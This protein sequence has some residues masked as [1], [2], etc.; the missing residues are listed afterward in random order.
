MSELPYEL[1]VVSY[2]FPIPWSENCLRATSYLNFSSIN[3]TTVCCSTAAAISC[4]CR[5]L[6]TTGNI[7]LWLVSSI[8]SVWYVMQVLP[9]TTI[10]YTAV[11]VVLR[12]CLVFVLRD[13]TV[14]RGCD[15]ESSQPAMTGAQ[16]SKVNERDCLENLPHSS[17]FR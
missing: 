1:P 12:Y 2:I 15:A 10:I 11:T 5:A 17:S 7:Y 8:F 6:N 4:C 9:S 13:L 16:D 3:T 14:E